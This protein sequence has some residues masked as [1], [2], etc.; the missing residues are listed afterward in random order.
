LLAGDLELTQRNMKK[1]VDQ[2]KEQLAINSR[3][4][5]VVKVFEEQENSRATVK[6]TPPGPSPHGSGKFSPVI[7]EAKHMK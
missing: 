1:T 6:G 4:L 2:L 5:G 3:L 7:R